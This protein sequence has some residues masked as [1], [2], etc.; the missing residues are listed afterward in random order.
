MYDILLKIFIPTVTVWAVAS[1]LL[2]MMVLIKFP[3]LL[4][5][6]NLLIRKMIIILDITFVSTMCVLHFSVLHYGDGTLTLLC[7]YLTYIGVVIVSSQFLT[8]AVMAIERYVFVV[9]PLKYGQLVTKSRSIAGLLSCILLPTIFTVVSESLSQRRLSLKSLACISD[10]P[11]VTL[12]RILLFVIPSFCCTL[13]I[14]V[15]MWKLTRKIH[16]TEYISFRPQTRKNF[17]LISFISGCLW[18]TFIPGAI[19]VA[20][21]NVILSGSPEYHDVAFY[22]YVVSTIIGSYISSSINPVIQFNVDK[23]LWIAVKKL[24]GKKVYFSYQKEYLEGII[25]GKTNTSTV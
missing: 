12:V 24:C 19:L 23:D 7:N 13:W 10:S 21:A 11:M 3:K 1:N 16:N 9:F 6:N 2:L 20:I 15:S 18:M 25:S 14:S 22:L 5:P 8:L 4:Q 17:R